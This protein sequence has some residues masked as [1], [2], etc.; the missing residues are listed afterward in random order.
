[1]NFRSLLCRGGRGDASRRDARRGPP[2]GAGYDSAVAIDDDALGDLLDE[3]G[4]GL[5]LNSAGPAIEPILAA[6]IGEAPPAAL[7]AAAAGAVEALWDAELETEI[8]TELEGFRAEVGGGD[9]TLVSRIDDA[10][11]GLA[12]PSPDNQVAHVLVWRAAAQLLRRANR[13]HERVAELERALERAPRT[14]HRRLTLPISGVASLAA[15]VG[16]EEAAKAVAEYAFTLSTSGRPSRKHHDRAAARLAERLATDER[17]ESVRASLAELAELSADEFPLASS[18][19][20]ELLGEPFPHDPV[21]DEIWINL[22]VGLAHEQLEDA[23]GD[24]A[25][26]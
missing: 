15:D 17:R 13:N 14:K 11:R 19:L 9:P 20:Q 8:R 10:L 22:V 24:E 6:L 23:L 25:A 5:E 3:I 26:D 4:I 12:E 21:K 1:V 16:D 2:A 7:H 18:A